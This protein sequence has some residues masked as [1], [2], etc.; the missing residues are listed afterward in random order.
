MSVGSPEMYYSV[1]IN[2]QF[3]TTIITFANS[4]KAVKK[5]LSSDNEGWY[6]CVIT[7]ECS[8]GGAGRRRPHVWHPR[9]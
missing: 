8:S 3:Y 5:V 4:N 1:Y 7:A 6:V 9:R 2:S